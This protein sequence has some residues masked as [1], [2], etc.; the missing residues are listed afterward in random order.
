MLRGPIRR[1]ERSAPFFDAAREGELLVRR[2]GACERF[3]SPHLVQCAGC[4]HAPLD[5]APASGTATLVTWTV[6]HGRDDGAGRRIVALAELDEG[7]WIS[8]ELLDIA[9]D[10]LAVG[11]SVVVDFW[12]VEGSEVVPVLRGRAHR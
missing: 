5:W 6:L 11:L 9:D 1:D 8:A 12:P 2:C 10:A 7:P 4:G 3:W